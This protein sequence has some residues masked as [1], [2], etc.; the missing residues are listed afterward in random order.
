MPN[1]QTD[2]FRIPRERFLSMLDNYT[3][4][5]VRV[6]EVGCGGWQEYSTENVIELVR[7]N[8]GEEVQVE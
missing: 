6:L 3:G 2:I 8:P 5:P 7:Q 1:G 4:G